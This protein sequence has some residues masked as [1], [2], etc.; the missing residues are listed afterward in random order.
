MRAISYEI[1]ALAL[2]AGSGFFFFRAVEFLAGK[3]Y[4]SGILTIVVGLA[5]IRTGVELS[6]LAILTRRERE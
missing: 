2:L 5:V 3:D 1:L 4:V 6:K